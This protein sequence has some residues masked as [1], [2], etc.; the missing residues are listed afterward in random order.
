MKTDPVLFVLPCVWVQW[1]DSSDPAGWGDFAGVDHDEKL[2]EVVVDS[3]APTLD[4]VDVG[5]PDALPDL[6]SAHLNSES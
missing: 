1:Y 3:A 5:S 6:N 2:H 4:D